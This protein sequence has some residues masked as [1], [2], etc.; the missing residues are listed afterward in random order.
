VISQYYAEPEIALKL[1]PGAFVPP[2]R[3]ASAL[4]RMRLPGPCAQM[5]ITDNDAFETFL[6]SCFSQKRKTLLNNL[7]PLAPV[8]K[9]TAAIATAGLKPQVR[10][11][12]L[13][14]VAFVELFRAL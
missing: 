8:E 2:P 13:P 1:P 3:V 6:Q 5:G 10:A 4:V 12:E 11:E 7:K 14:L 9:V